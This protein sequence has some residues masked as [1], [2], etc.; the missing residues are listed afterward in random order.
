MRQ[1]V[2]DGDRTVTVWRPC[3]VAGTT[4]LRPDRRSCPAT[5]TRARRA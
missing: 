2:T 1:A 5:T 4:S 3:H